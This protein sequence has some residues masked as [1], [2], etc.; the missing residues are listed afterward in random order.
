MTGGPLDA[1]GQRG[2]NLRTMS[3]DRRTFLKTLTLGGVA[4]FTDDWFQLVAET[5][6]ATQGK[7][8]PVHPAAV[9]GKGCQE[10]NAFWSAGEG[11]ALYLNG[12]PYDEPPTRTYRQ[13]LEADGDD[14]VIEALEQL[15]QGKYEALDDVEQLD[16]EAEGGKDEETWREF[17]GRKAPSLLETLEY[18][19]S[20]GLPTGS[21][22]LDEDIDSERDEAFVTD[23]CRRNA[24]EAAASVFL[25]GLIQGLRSD[26]E[27]IRLADAIEVEGLRFVDG[28]CPGNDTLVCA[29]AN[30]YDT[31]AALQRILG[32]RGHNCRVIILQANPADIAPAGD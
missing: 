16:E 7:Q 32:A 8:L 24:P 25:S 14:H 11:Y 19:E 22:M 27:E 10:L 9:Y 3:H 20:E 30:D 21:W 12:T 15:G 31:L 13:K 28:A 6:E 26:R 18:I 17:I 2:Y 5:K 23:W 29:Y 4:L 1:N